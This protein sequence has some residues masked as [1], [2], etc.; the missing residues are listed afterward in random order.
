MSPGMQG[1]PYA[2]AVA[3]GSGFLPKG[4]RFGPYQRRFRGTASHG[5]V[6]QVADALWTHNPQ[7]RGKWTRFIVP[8][9]GLVIRA[10]CIAC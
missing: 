5:L 1:D 8:I 10:E 7:R 4:V 3:T 9:P 6:D 2:L